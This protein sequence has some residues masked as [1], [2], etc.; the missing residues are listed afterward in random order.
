VDNTKYGNMYITDNN[1]NELL[2]YGLYDSGGNR[3][4]AMATKPQVGDIV[5][6]C[7]P[8]LNYKVTTVEIKNGTLISI[9]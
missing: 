2:I 6:I 3:Y 7:G 9:E 8:I 1:G 4:D 5:I